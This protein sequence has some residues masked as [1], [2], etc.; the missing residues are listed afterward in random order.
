[1]ALAATAVGH[2]VGSPAPLPTCL[3]AVATGRIAL[4]SAAQPEHWSVR[5]ARWPV[6]RYIG[7]TTFRGPFAYGRKRPLAWWLVNLFTGTQALA[8]CRTAYLLAPQT[9]TRQMKVIS[10]KFPK[11]FTSSAIIAVAGMAFPAMA[12]ILACK[13][14]CESTSQSR[15]MN[16]ATQAQFNWVRGCGGSSACWQASGSVFSAAYSTYMN[17]YMSSCMNQCYTGQ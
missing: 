12:D 2:R 16:D 6:C 1:M 7:P 4:R 14:N 8:T 13:A 10:S 5:I 15:A 3:R 9:G 17:G 11:N